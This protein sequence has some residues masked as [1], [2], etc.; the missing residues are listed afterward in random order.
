MPSNG[1][2]GIRTEEGKREPQGSERRREGGGAA[3]RSAAQRSPDGV[4]GDVG[5]EGNLLVPRQLGEALDGDGARLEEEG[6]GV[7]VRQG[8][9]VHHQPELL[10][11]VESL[12][13]DR[14]GQVG[15]SRDGTAGMTDGVVVG[16][17]ES[18][19][20]IRR[21]GRAHVVAVSDGAVEGAGAGLDPAEAGRGSGAG[22]LPGETHAGTREG[23]KGRSREIERGAERH[24]AYRRRCCCC[25][26]RELGSA[27]RQRAARL[28][29]WLAAAC[30]DGEDR[31]GE[32][33]GLT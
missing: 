27:E 3:W 26:R 18:W 30:A 23:R 5:G 31:P 2:E 24:A 32:C 9:R 10:A 13:T 6:R 17:R 33:W 4:G 15:V 21:A 14:R 29:G 22:E 8:E 28:A 7:G 16:G 12:S 19:V 11:V 25:S 1:S 20:E